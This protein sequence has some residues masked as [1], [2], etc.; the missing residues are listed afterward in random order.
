MFRILQTAYYNGEEVTIHGH[1]GLTDIYTVYNKKRDI[2]YKLKENE[3]SLTP[4]TKNDKK[5]VK[6]LK[7]FNRFQDKQINKILDDENKARDVR[8]RPIK[9]ALSDYYV[10]E[11]WE[12]I[13]YQIAKVRTKNKDIFYAP[14]LNYKSLPK[15]AYTFD[16]AVLICLGYKYDGRSDSVI[17]VRRLLNMSNNHPKQ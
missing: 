8:L 13:D 6:D 15:F 9:N 3:L 4:Q 12:M 16:D 7:N 11:I 14:F 5:T 1:N 10:E 17:Y 2:I